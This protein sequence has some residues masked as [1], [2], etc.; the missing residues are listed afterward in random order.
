MAAEN[1]ALNN[2]IV[3]SLANHRRD[4]HDNRHAPAAYDRVKQVIDKAQF[5]QVSS[6]GVLSLAVRWIHK[7]NSRA[8]QLEIVRVVGEEVP[9]D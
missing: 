9:A 6:R 1:V 2:F 7:A 8:E 5:G 4:R 3:A